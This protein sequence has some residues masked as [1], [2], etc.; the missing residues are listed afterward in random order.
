M[1]PA[2]PLPKPEEI[3]QSAIDW[4][5]RQEWS[6]LISIFLGII[7]GLLVLYVVLKI[8][9]RKFK[10]HRMVRTMREDLLLRRELA[11]MAS[12]ESSKPQSKEQY[13]RLESIK[14]D[15]LTEI[16]RMK[17]NHINPADT[18]SF[19]LLGEPGSGKTRLATNGGITFPF[20]LNDTTLNQY[21]TSTVNLWIAEHGAI[22]DIGG[23]VFLNRWGNQKDK[24]WAYFLDCL[25]KYRKGGP[26]AGA[27]LTIPADALLFDNNE[28]R[29][30]KI[31]LIAEELRC[32]SQQQGIRCPI[33]VI[34]TKS[35]FI[36]GFSE[37]FACIPEQQ[38][39]NIL[40]WVHQEKSEQFDV[41]CYKSNFAH[42]VNQLFE[43]RNSFLLN[44]SLWKITDSSNNRG[45]LVAPIF[46]FPEQFASIEKNLKHYLSGIFSHVRQKSERNDLVFQGCWFTATLDKP[47]IVEEKQAP[48]EDIPT[49]TLD[50]GEETAP[51]KIVPVQVCEKIASTYSPRHYFTKNLLQNH[52][53]TENSLS[54]YTRE[55]RRHVRTPYFIGA[56]FLIVFS[57]LLIFFSFVEGFYLKKMSS[58]N[59]NFWAMTEQMFNDQT[60][61]NSPVISFDK[62]HQKALLTNQ[63]GKSSISRQEFLTQLKNQVGA[64]ETI[65]RFWFLPAAFFDDNWTTNLL[66]ADK[67]FINKAAVVHMLLKPSVDTTRQMF[68]EQPSLPFDQ[69]WTLTDTDV[70]MELIKLTK[71]GILLME[72]QKLTDDLNYSLFIT[73]EGNPPLESTVESLI[74]SHFDTNPTFSTMTILNGYLSPVS[75]DAARGIRSA[76]SSYTRELNAHTIYPSL[77]YAT[78]MS[79]I[80]YLDKLQT[81]KN[82]LKGVEDKITDIIIENNLSSHDNLL[83]QWVDIYHQLNDTGNTLYAIEQKLDITQGISLKIVAERLKAR[84]KEQLDKDQKAFEAFLEGSGNSRNSNFLRSEISATLSKL[85]QVDSWLSKDNKRISQELS[86]LWDK[87]ENKMPT[88]PWH[89][90]I[91]QEKRIYD[92][93]TFSL[94]T[95]SSK[96]SFQTSI[97]IFQDSCNLYDTTTDSLLKDYSSLK[98]NKS[99]WQQNRRRLEQKV[100]QSWLDRTPKSKEEIAT[101]IISQSSPQKLP[102]LEYTPSCNTI[103]DS[104]YSPKTADRLTADI[105]TLVSFI[106]SKLDK[107]ATNETAANIASITDEL[108]DNLTNYIK[109]YLVYWLDS[110]PDQ[111]L[112]KDIRTWPHFVGSASIMSGHA[113][114][115][116]SREANE[117]IIQAINISYLTKKEAKAS[118]PMAFQMNADLAGYN[119]LLT[120]EYSQI[121]ENT[122]DRIA[123]LPSDPLEAWNHLRTLTSDEVTEQYW[124]PWLMTERNISE[125]WW[126]NYLTYGFRL[127]KKAA[128]NALI[129]QL[130][131]AL[132]VALNFPLCNTS[133][134]KTSSI[135]SKIYIEDLSDNFTQL[136]RIAKNKES[137]KKFSK[138]KLMN[139][140][141]DLQDMNLLDD[142]QKAQSW[143][144]VFNIIDLIANKTAPLT[145]YLTLPPSNTRAGIQEFQLKNKRLIPVA[146]RYPYYRISL[147]GKYITPK[148]LFCSTNKEEETLTNSEF[149]IEA[150]DLEFHFFKHS[151]MTEPD[152][153]VRY[154]GEWSALNVYLSNRTK[155]GKDKTSAQVPLIFTDKEGYSCLF[156]IGIHFNSPMISPADWP[157]YNT[158]NSRDIPMPDEEAKAQKKLR[159]L[160]NDKFTGA[161]GKN[162]A[163][164]SP[165]KSEKLIKDILALMGNHYLLNFNVF[166]PS[167]IDYPNEEHI[168][169]CA[170]YKY[171]SI[172]EEMLGTPK[173]VTLPDI[174]Q[175]LTSSLAGEQKATIKLF[176]HAYDDLPEQE[177][178]ISESILEFAIRHASAYNPIQGYFTIPVQIKDGNT[179]YHFHLFLSPQL[180]RGGDTLLPNLPTSQFQTV[181]PDKEIDDTD[182]NYTPASTPPEP[183]TTLVP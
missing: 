127:L 16:R 18:P 50:Q 118:F 8:V 29:D 40:G 129:T 146:S 20:G 119:K 64:E 110:V 103:I 182:N 51:E 158:W 173:E 120:T 156:W 178:T 11:T 159:S 67:D 155:L 27:I 5:Q 123:D 131:A 35:D 62:D 112:I 38:V 4:L 83:S 105:Q 55:K 138:S 13:L 24:E 139:I 116:S 70:M 32:L 134:R 58:R 100:F 60:I 154:E 34:V 148:L 169:A 181:Y 31:G 86:D 115:N 167:A 28:L 160:L 78:F 59:I 132:P 77:E 39:P 122:L 63:L 47:T 54:E 141:E 84:L 89:D 126:N 48:K 177:I 21:A 130:D 37:F 145:W 136:P 163:P 96:D 9:I 147:G 61:Q 14:L 183:S 144:K 164:I 137:D 152:V 128:T 1:N 26:I 124:A 172:S 30:K 162:L 49:T 93:L 69:N 97:K 175:S 53:L 33:W 43:A 99:F 121:C 150:A 180:S 104:R 88:R 2:L 149:P 75:P 98:L 133:E 95:G 143:K 151:D 111:Y 15:V 66:K 72:G 153:K 76:L 25:S 90:F 23:C 170:R 102:P 36:P 165:A 94:G 135:L 179:I 176:L 161:H 107:T 3:N 42:I 73:L 81:L 10:V 142:S 108:D 57:L 19:L 113:I 117:L 101:R 92:L 12:G 45:N 87:Q 109:D 17:A 114:N 85:T 68:F 125:R 91:T 7:L 71:Y 171:F 52:I 106:Q 79:F 6:T 166:T 168:K 44:N 157:D 22:W 65:S 80:D 74:V 41:E 174:S 56:A 82:K 140:P 46:N